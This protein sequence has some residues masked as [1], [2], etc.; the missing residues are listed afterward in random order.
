LGVIFENERDTAS[1]SAQWLDDRCF[2][3]L[4]YFKQGMTKF[5]SAKAL[6]SSISTLVAQF[7]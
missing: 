5:R 7:I 6:G 1:I 4:F 2:V 3:T